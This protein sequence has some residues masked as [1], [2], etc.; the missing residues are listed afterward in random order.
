[1]ETARLNGNTLEYLLAMLPLF[2][3]YPRLE[4]RLP[5]VP[6]AEIPTPVEAMKTLGAEL[7]VPGL[8][9]KRDDLSGRPYG[10]N[11]V[12]K[13]E[14]LLGCALRDGRKAVLT[15]GGAGSNHATATA[16]YARRLGL[17][18]INMLMPQPNAHS[19]RR[20]LL[21]S[22]RAGADL[23]HFTSGAALRAGVRE[24]MLQHRRNNGVFPMVIP[25]GGSSPVGLLGFVNAAFELKQQVDAGLLPEPDRVY[26][27]SGTMGTVVGLA[28]GFAA[29]GLRTRVM[30]VRVT[31][32]PY[33]SLDKAASLFRTAIAL[34][35]DADPS[36]P[37]IAFSEERVELLHDFIGPQYGIYTEAAVAAARQAK[38]AEHLKLEG[39][40]TGK[41]LAALLAHA[42]SGALRDQT[43]LFWN[44][45]NS[46][47]FSAEIEGLD[48][49]EL[50]RPF[51]VYFEEDVQLLDR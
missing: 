18:S 5:H 22:H 2:E 42:S 9:V 34:L 39:T 38:I 33:T 1:M 32:P 23:H 27:A 29:A 8:Y 4:S 50:P 45:Y 30:A 21:M 12:R 35:R 7:G 26:A 44:T 17:A 51:H 48:Y 47:D 20:N 25:P 11:K 49:R 13:L 37:E 10:G 31:D 16:I 28:L 24:Q 14:F 46:W 41:T 36:F 6:L 19:V 40:Y 3:Q 15:F 43:V